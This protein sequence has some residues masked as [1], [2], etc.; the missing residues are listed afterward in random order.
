[1][2]K[3]LPKERLF[4]SIAILDEQRRDLLLTGYGQTAVD[5]IEKCELEFAP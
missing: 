3:M 4:I 2:M 1:M 5:L